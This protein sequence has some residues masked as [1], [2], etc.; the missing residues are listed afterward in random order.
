M[1]IF[2]F[3]RHASKIL[4]IYDCLAQAHARGLHPMDISRGTG[5]SFREVARRLDDTP[6][7]FV[8]LVVARGEPRRY[9]LN[10]RVRAMTRRQVE[11]LVRR[12]VLR[13]SLILYSLIAMIVL[14]FA[15][16]LLSAMPLYVFA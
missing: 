8:R 3:R 16:L 14:A 12:A 9:T 10:T 6:E 4:G 13:E 11:A 15:T 7:L 1:K 2:R 5:I